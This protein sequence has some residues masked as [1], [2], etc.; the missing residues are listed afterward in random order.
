MIII[1]FVMPIKF[2]WY[3]FIV[4]LIC[5]NLPW[6]EVGIALGS[7]VG[8]VLG[9]IVGCEVGIVVG[10]SVGNWDGSELGSTVGSKYYKQD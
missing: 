1:D 10:V 2:V 5:D 4:W 9:I 6:D 3:R 8:S 7:L